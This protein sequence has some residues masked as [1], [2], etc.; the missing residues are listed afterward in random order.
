MK[1][2]AFLCNRAISSHTG[3]SVW[4]ITWECHSQDFLKFHNDID[5][6]NNNREAN[7]AINF[8]PMLQEQYPQNAPN[9]NH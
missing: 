9:N 2:Q 1:L 4:Y 5:Y 6:P 8:I 7:G 3:N